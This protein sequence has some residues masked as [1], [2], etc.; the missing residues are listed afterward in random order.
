MKSPR[1][2]FIKQTAYTTAGLGL[3]AS[4][5][6]A[7]TSGSKPTDESQ[8]EA[9]VATAVSVDPLFFK[10]SLAQWSL[11]NGFFGDALDK[12]WP[13]F[14]EALVKDPQS[15]L[16]GDL[17]PLNFPAIAKNEFG[18]DA[19]EYVNIFFYDKGKDQQYLN[20]LKQR[21][22]DNGVSSLLI[23]CDRLGDL[24]ETNDELRRT[25]VENHY[26]WVEAAKFLGC[27]SIRVNAA[28]SG[29]AAEVQ[30][31]AIDGLGRLS[32][33]GAEAGINII[34]EN[35]GGY[36]SDGMWL[37]EVMRQVNMDNCGT[38]PDFGN[39]CIES[40]DDGCI[41]EYDRYKGV[42]ELMPYAKGV[43]AKSHDFDVSGNETHTDYTKMLT[44]VKE[45][46]YTGHI[47]IEYEGSVMSESDGIKATKTLL[48]KTGAALT[49]GV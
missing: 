18:I 30:Q 36:S 11:H 39:F 26:P 3:S 38:L 14:N 27:H 8:N 10:I 6:N 2:K 19:V 34:V 35:H 12:G 20:K 44:I 24:G 15:I 21:C 41:N 42:A 32:E 13:V 37:S 49:S 28:G 33:Y 23:M 5:L 16:R 25:A 48:E 22:E 7:C 29:T 43:S 40:G 47:G 1:R 31:A 45:A 17:D 4:I 9:P 46:G